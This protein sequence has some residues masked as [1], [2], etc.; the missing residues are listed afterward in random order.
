MKNQ[1]NGKKL[2]LYIMAVLN[3]CSL[4]R[5]AD[6]VKSK[7][8]NNKK[9]FLIYSIFFV[10]LFEWSSAVYLKYFHGVTNVTTDF[11]DA[12]VSP[13][14]TNASLFVLMFSLFLWKDRLHFCFRKSST[15]F[16][17]SCYYLFNAVS[18]L[19]CLNASIYYGIIAYAFLIIATFLFIVSL[20]NSKK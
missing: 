9:P 2:K 11:Y 20:L 8:E 7:L 6:F 14:L 10:L 3:S 13:F 15:A 19:F 4:C 1:L 12:K 5:P 18:V 17:L 16:Y